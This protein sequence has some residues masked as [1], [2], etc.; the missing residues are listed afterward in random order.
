[1]GAASS[2]PLVRARSRDA[3]PPAGAT[4]F[5]TAASFDDAYETNDKNLNRNSSEMLIGSEFAKSGDIYDIGIRIPSITIA[6]G[7]TIDSAFMRL[8]VAGFNG[9]PSGGVGFTMFADQD[10][11]PSTWANNDRPSGITL[12]GSS[13]TSTISVTG[14]HSFGGI[15]LVTMM[16]EQID[17]PG[18]ASGNAV[19]FWLRRD[20]SNQ[21][22][23]LITS[24]NQSPNTNRPSLLLIWS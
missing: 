8:E 2:F 20:L 1:M 23:A 18:W 12:G 13:I 10:A 14:F 24:H 11:N 16:Q 19:R 9:D 22:N 6:P 5:L 3:A 15:S 17:L 7:Q 4:T 21:V